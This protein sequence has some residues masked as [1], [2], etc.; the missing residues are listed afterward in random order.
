M[1]GSPSVPAPPPDVAALEAAWRAL[2]PHATLP[3]QAWAW[4]RA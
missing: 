1:P 2:E 4:V 3:T